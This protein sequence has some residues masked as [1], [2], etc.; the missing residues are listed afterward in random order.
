MNAQPLAGLRIVNTRASRQASSLTRLLEAEGAEVLH[1]PTVEIKPCA[2]SGKLDAALKELAAGRFDWLVITS[3]NTVYTLADRLRTLGIQ[4]ARIAQH[5]TKVAAVGS[6]TASA[7]REELNLSVDLLPDAYVAES[8]A[9]SLRV[10]R[11]SRV[12]L[13]QS[14]LARPLL[15]NTLRRVGAEV[16]AVTAYRTVVGHGGD[17]LP[18][19][20]RQ[21]NVDAVVFTSASTVH[22]FVERL[23]AEIPEES[24]EERGEGEIPAGRERVSNCSLLSSYFSQLNLAVACIGPKTAEAAR[25]H[26]LPVQVVADD[27]TVEGLVHSLKAYFAGH[28]R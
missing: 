16:A 18:R 20:F 1:Y 7:V 19:H 15:V 28:P 8:L 23:K 17:D 12:L 21:G 11:G 2:D 5:S 3:A 6:A 9:A 26:E 13:P 22:N 14:A 27:R 10:G 4:H 24:Q 25:G